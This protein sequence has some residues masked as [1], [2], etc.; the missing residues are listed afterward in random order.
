M[1]FRDERESDTRPTRVATVTDG[2]TVTTGNYPRHRRRIYILIIILYHV[3]KLQYYMDCFNH[4]SK[5]TK[6]I[7]PAEHGTYGSYRSQP[8]RGPLHIWRI[9]G[10]VSDE[11]SN[12]FVRRFKLVNKSPTCQSR[13]VEDDE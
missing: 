8:S 6:I 12:A 4:K 11:G 9:S 5:Q 13:N 3:L 1:E 7:L 10:Q 2:V